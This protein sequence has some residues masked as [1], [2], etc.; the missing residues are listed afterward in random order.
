M[1][2]LNEELKVLKARATL[3]EQEVDKETNPQVKE[4][5]RKE[6]TALRNQITE[7]L[8][9]EN[10]LL[11]QS[12][13]KFLFIRREFYFLLELVLYFQDSFDHRGLV[14]CAILAVLIVFI[15]YSRPSNYSKKQFTDYIFENY[16]MDVWY[17]QYDISYMPLTKTLFFNLGSPSLKRE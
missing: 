8:K 7:L 12:R 14:V 2:E 13:G 9:K 15:D 4:S 10:I 17:V 6:L 16:G 11:E 1:D 5:I 3:L